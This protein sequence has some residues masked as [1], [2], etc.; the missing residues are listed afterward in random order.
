MESFN[1]SI[2]ELFWSRKLLRPVVS[3]LFEYN[4]TAIFPF[5]LVMLF[6]KWNININQ[7]KNYFNHFLDTAILVWDAIFSILII[8]KLRLYK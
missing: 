4:V 2:T 7:L 5:D 6:S 3:I 1:P 8:S